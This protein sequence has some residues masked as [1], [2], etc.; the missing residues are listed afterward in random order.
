[1]VWGGWAVGT[2]LGSQLAAHSLVPSALGEAPRAEKSEASKR[3]D[4][5]ALGDGYTRHP[6][7]GRTLWGLRR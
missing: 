4:D 1:M 3:K 7:P 5:P 2:V 6:T